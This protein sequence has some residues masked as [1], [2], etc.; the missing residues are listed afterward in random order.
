MKILIT[1]IKGFLGS[2]LVNKLNDFSIVGLGT[3]DDFSNSIPVFG[4]LDDIDNNIDVVILCHAAV[5]SGK[6]VLSNDKLY[7]VNIS[8]TEKIINKFKNSH[9]IYISSTSVYHLNG[10]IQNE[11][12][13]VSPQSS[14]ALSKFWAEKIVSNHERNTILRISSLFGIGMKENTLIPNYINQALQNGIIEVW[15]NG[16]RVQNYIHVEDVVTY[17]KLII[18]NRE[19]LNGEV[20]LGVSEEHYSNLDIANIVADYLKAKIQFIKED[21]SISFK[22]NNT[23]TR[24]LLNWTSESNIETSLQRY[25]EWKKKY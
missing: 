21:N 20:L 23:Y 3:K 6:V 2:N 15:G 4:H 14:Y 12:S 25:I 8:L 9:I 24:D 7:E 11:K 19:K 16:G 5:A 17:I 1:G 22:Y 13:I 18:K 10:E